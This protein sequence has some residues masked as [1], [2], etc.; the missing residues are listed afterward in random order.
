MSTS[1]PSPENPVVIYGGELVAPTA[2][3]PSSSLASHRIP[4]KWVDLEAEPDQVVEVES[5]NNGKRIIPTIVFAD[6]P[7]SRKPSNDELADRIGLSAR[8]VARHVRP[9]HHSGADPPDFT[10]AIYAARGKT[11]RC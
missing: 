5:R 7:S 8:R 11:P 3:A 1:T 2:G 6:G 10:T 4:Y 9:S